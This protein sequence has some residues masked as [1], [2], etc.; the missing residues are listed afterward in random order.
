MPSKNEIAEVGRSIPFVVD[1]NLADAE[2]GMGFMML[3]WAST[4]ADV[5]PPYWSQAR[6]RWLRQFVYTN[7]PIK[8]AVNTFVNKLVTIPWSIQS[9]DRTISRHVLAAEQ[10]EG[11]LRRLSGS[12]SSS[13]LRGFKS[14]FKMF[15]KDYLTQDN[16]AFMLILG[17]GPADGPIVGAPS[18]MMHLDS[19]LCIR[20]RDDRYP[21]KY[22]NTGRGG[23][24]K[25]YKIHYT[26]IIEMCNLPSSEVDLNG[27]GLCPVSC[28]LEAAQELYDIYQYNREMFGSKPPRQILYAKKGATVKTMVDAIQAWQLK[29][30]QDSRTHFG[31]TLLMAPRGMGQEMELD[32]VDL[33][34][35]PEDFNRR[36]VTT[37]D[38]SEIAA[39]FGLDLRD[40]S[41]T[42][43]APSRTGDAEVQDR[44][45]RGKGIGEFIET[46][47]ERVEENYLNGD[48]FMMRFDNMDDEQDEQ[49]ASIRDKRSTGRERDLRSGVTTVRVERETMWTGG[50]ITYE[51]FCEMELQDGRLPEGLDVLLLF[52]SEDRDYREWLDIGVAD[53][54]NVSK[55]DPQAMADVI[56]EKF[57]ELSR[58]IHEET[59]TERRRKARQALAALDKLRSMYQVPEGQAITDQATAEA[60]G[61]GSEEG[62]D[63]AAEDATE[64]D[65]GEDAGRSAP[66]TDETTIVKE[67]NLGI[68]NLKQLNLDDADLQQYEQQFRYLIE[69]AVSRQISRERFEGALEQIVAAVIM[70]LFARGSFMSFPEMTEEARVAVSELVEANWQALNSFGS[71]IF[72]RGLYDEGGLGLAG[73]LTRVAMWLTIASGAYYMGMTFRPDDPYLRWNYS[74][75]KEHCSDCARLHG[76]VHTASEWRAAGW[77]PR[78][79]GLECFGVHCGC[80]FTQVNGPSVGAF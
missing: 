62:V 48:L 54:T 6:D 10:L 31:G 27:I 53:P 36:D 46:F 3:R 41:Y 69:Q 59:R 72:D 50:E 8:T 20:T 7:G 2:G 49:E 33:A 55:N 17:D 1:E 43:G 13:A 15:A 21:V 71:D 52:Q 28:C 57:I 47:I 60:M 18:G 80:Y 40:L 11:T 45:G 79:T 37:I 65:S 70:S 39:A 12:M 38:K 29:L 32:K 24:N 14:A 64:E 56:H 34:R 26:R 5:I 23:D 35:M 76:Q 61:A 74:I 77:L 67:L 75:L 16:G 63:V 51:Q 4:G 25:E 19:A 22:L 44:K 66:S 58:L 30:A 9:R 73:A 68:A 78:S 42:L